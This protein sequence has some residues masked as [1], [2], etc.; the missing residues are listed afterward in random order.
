MTGAIGAGVTATTGMTVTDAVEV[1]VTGARVTVT[2]GAV[3]DAEA[4]TTVRCVMFP[5][6]AGDR[7]LAAPE[8]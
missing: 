1:D 6:I 3:M 8:P 4:A 7:A 5:A 2:A